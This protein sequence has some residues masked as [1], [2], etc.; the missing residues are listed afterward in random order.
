MKLFLNPKHNLLH[1]MKLT[2]E[3]GCD[4]KLLE[5]GK[6]LQSNNKTNRNKIQMN[7]EK[8]QENGV[9]KVL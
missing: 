7:M 6:H 4:E 3:K 9:N 8:L 2:T 5:N 1:K